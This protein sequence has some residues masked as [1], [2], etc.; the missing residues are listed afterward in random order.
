M[1]LLGHE[2]SIQFYL[3]AEFSRQILLGMGADEKKGRGYVLYYTGH[4]LGAILA[5]VRAV[6]DNTIAVTF[7]SPG[8]AEFL[9]PFLEK[10]RN[11]LDVKFS[12][13]VNIVSYLFGGPNP[14][15]TLGGQLG[16]VVE[17]PM[18]QQMIL[19]A[20]NKEQEE[21]EKE[22]NEKV[23]K[24]GS[25]SPGASS[26]SSSSSVQDYL[27]RK[28]I[29]K[30]VPK[31][32]LTFLETKVVPLLKSE[33]SEAKQLHSIATIVTHFEQ[34]DDVE[35]VISRVEREVIRW[36]KNSFQFLEYR[37][38]VEKVSS[39][40]SS[41]ASVGSSS[42]MQQPVQNAYKKL[43]HEC[44]F[45]ALYDVCFFPLRYL[46]SQSQL[47]LLLFHLERQRGKKQNNNSTHKSKNKKTNRRS[48]TEEERKSPNTEINFY[49]FDSSEV[50]VLSQ[51]RLVRGGGSG[52]RIE[53]G[54]E[55]EG[56]KG[57]EKKNHNSRNGTTATEATGQ[58]VIMVESKKLSHLE[59][60]QYLVF[61]LLSSAPS[62]SSSSSQPFK[63]TNK[64][65]GGIKEHEKHLLEL[66]L[67]LEKESETDNGSDTRRSRAQ[68]SS[69]PPS[70]RFSFFSN[71]LSYWVRSLLWW[72]AT[73]ADE[74]QDKHNSCQRV[75]AKL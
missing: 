72:R 30:F 32:V 25:Q 62:S 73:D 61:L 7:E 11:N 55:E 43:V 34:H 69:Q 31:N 48:S 28:L 21:K 17:I 42:S 75:K 22:E 27:Q 15:N 16:H 38:A 18:Q 39:F 49:F 4:S 56:Q 46:P 52:K 24:S 51:V 10:K 2:P 36:P 50:R 54:E 35:E 26:P 47:V 58:T 8:C 57:S 64:I 63:N 29:E 60:R 6:E 12:G 65:F 59:L 9:Y 68:P 44:Y 45:T 3:A 19:L 66:R 5:A 41:S 70:S 33:L 74:K 13:D 20:E 37:N 53:G 67:N 71:A 23:K 1:I 40:S 14:V